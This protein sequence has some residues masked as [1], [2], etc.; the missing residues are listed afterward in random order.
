M[1]RNKFQ[2]NNFNRW[3]VTL[4]NFNIEIVSTLN[5]FCGKIINSLETSENML[6]LTNIVSMKDQFGKMTRRH[7]CHPNT[8]TVKEQ[9]DRRNRL[10]LVLKFIEVTQQNVKTN[11]L[12]SKKTSA[13]NKDQQLL[14]SSRLNARPADELNIRFKRSETKQYKHSNYLTW[15]VDKTMPCKT[16]SD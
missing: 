13:L 7:E 3:T 12:D 6:I 16:I 5:T 9:I 11:N 4:K 1:L 2:K 10:T 15:M 8:I 14:F